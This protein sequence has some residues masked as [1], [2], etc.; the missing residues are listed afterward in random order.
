[1]NSARGDKPV[2]DPKDITVVGRRLLQARAD[3]VRHAARAQAAQARTAKAHVAS[4]RKVAQSRAAG[5]AIWSGRLARFGYR[6]GRI[7]GGSA[8]RAAKSG[9]DATKVAAHSTVDA[10][11]TTL[12]ERSAHLALTRARAPLPRPSTPA[13]VRTCAPHIEARSGKTLSRRR[14][15]PR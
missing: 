5:D 2:A 14:P 4:A 11:K 7:G 6:R 10:A 13:G 8:I 15:G 9:F 1:M 3:A 12:H